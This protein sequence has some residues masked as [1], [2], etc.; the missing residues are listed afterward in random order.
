MDIFQSQ[1]F[2]ASLSGLSNTTERL[3]R[4]MK[5]D[6]RMR[7]ADYAEISRLNDRLNRVI[8]IIPAAFGIAGATLGAGVDS[9]VFP[10][11]GLPGFGLPP[12]FP[13]LGPPGGGGSR[14]RT[15]RYR[16]RC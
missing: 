7:K 8:P 3:A 10:P 11:F 14:K 13:P 6:A 9:G 16:S 1:R 2:A 12:L 4:I 15:K 5:N